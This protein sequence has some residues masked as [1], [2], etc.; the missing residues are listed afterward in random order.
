MPTVVAEL[1]RHD[2][3]K[4]AIPLDVLTLM[5]LMQVNAIILHLPKALSSPTLFISELLCI[6]EDLQNLERSISGMVRGYP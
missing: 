6:T 1:P 3:S 5:D 4:T 2:P